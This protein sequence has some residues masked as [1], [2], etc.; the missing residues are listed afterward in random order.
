LIPSQQVGQIFRIDVMQPVLRR[1]DT[2]RFQVVY[3]T[4]S[5]FTFEVLKGIAYCLQ[6]SGLVPR[7][8]LIGIGYPGDC[9]EAGALLRN[10]DM[11]F[12]GQ[13]RFPVEPPDMEGV[14]W[15]AEGTPDFHGGEAF[16]RFIELELIP[17]VDQRYSTVRGDR[18]YFG[19]SL[20]GGFGLTTLFT[21]PHLFNRYIISSPSVCYHGNG[22]EQSDFLIHDARR[23]VSNGRVANG[24]RLYLSAGTEEELEPALAPWR[25]TSSFYRMAAVLE[26]GAMPGLDLTTEAFAGERHMTVWPM[27]FTHGLQAIFDPLAAP[28]EG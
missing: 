21:Q 17:F 25:M 19:H 3:A 20:G 27:A 22:G 9:P 7:F 6:A 14:L 11:T 10:R 24:A 16:Q 13:P 2:T 18:A 8:I 1:G 5:N 26:A 23:F 4:D 28:E 12:P 15:P